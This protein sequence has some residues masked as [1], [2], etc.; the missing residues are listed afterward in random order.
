MAENIGMIS[1]AYDC[2]ISLQIML[3]L[4]ISVN[5]CF[6]NFATKLIWASKIFD[7]KLQPNG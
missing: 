4:L 2:P 1:F 3:N 5:F 7:G 6:P